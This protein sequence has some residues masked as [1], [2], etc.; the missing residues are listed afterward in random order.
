MLTLTALALLHLDCA[1]LQRSAAFEG[2]PGLHARV[3]QT[4]DDRVQL[5]VGSHTLRV[6]GS[7]TS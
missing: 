1:A 3:T 5:H 7:C 4:A 2:R 6:G